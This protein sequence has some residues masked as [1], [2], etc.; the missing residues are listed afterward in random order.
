MKVRLNLATTPLET[1]RS[2]AVGA[3]LVGGFGVLAM[4]ILS[5]HAFVVWHANTQMRA[6]Q[7][8]IEQDMNRLRAERS[9]IEA[10]F[11][12]PSTVQEQD[13]AGF[14]NSLIAQRAF[15][16]TKI[17]MDFE[18]NLPSGVRVVSIEPRLVADHL[19]LRFI[20]AAADD[21]SKLKFLKA[22]EGAPEFSQIEVFS[23]S[24]TARP[25]DADHIVLSLQAR[26]SAT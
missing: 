13:R 22:L 15:P 18:R 12:Q 23:E 17:F 1:N 5:W 11:S 14:L 3:A 7:T 4:L 24:R 2:F 16:W 21:D 20:V 8:K 25:N 26:Y 19:E 9:G 10:F 6:E